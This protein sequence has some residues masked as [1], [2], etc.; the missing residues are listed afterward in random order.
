VGLGILSALV[1]G[2]GEY[3]WGI[4]GATIIFILVWFAA[5]LLRK[6]TLSNLS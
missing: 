6:S 4:V 5:F 2:L 1:I 3:L